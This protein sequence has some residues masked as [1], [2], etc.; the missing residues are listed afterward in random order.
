MVIA[1]VVSIGPEGTNGNCGVVLGK[2]ISG[3]V[4]TGIFHEVLKGIVVLAYLVDAEEATEGSEAV[5]YVV[6][7]SLVLLNAV[8]KYVLLSTSAYISNNASEASEG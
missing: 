4:F 3:P 6:P 8:S 5:L 2:A 7:E 1:Y